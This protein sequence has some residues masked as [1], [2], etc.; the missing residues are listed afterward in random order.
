MVILAVGRWLI[1]KKSWVAVK[2]KNIFADCRDTERWSGIIKKFIPPLLLTGLVFLV[3]HKS[4]SYFFAQDDFVWLRIAASVKKATQLFDFFL[5]YNGAGSYRPLTQEVFFFL[6][7]KLFGLNPVP[8][9]LVT[10]CVHTI[11]SLLVYGILRQMKLPRMACLAGAIF[12]GLNS[13]VFIPVYWI[14]AISESGMALFY[15]S[16]VLLFLRY[17]QEGRRIDYCLSFAACVFALMSKEPAITIPAILLLTYLY[18]RN[19]FTM[20][21]FVRGVRLVLPFVAVVAVYLGIRFAFVGIV[22]GG[23]YKPEFNTLI[24][25]NLWDFFKWSLNDLGLT[26]SLLAQ[27]TQY[28]FLPAIHIAFMLLLA[29]AGLFLFVKEKR[30][31]LFSIL[32]FVIALVPVLPYV[33]HAQNYYVNI[34]VVG[35]SVLVA[36]LVSKY[37]GRAKILVGGLMALYILSSVANVHHQED[38]SW[39]AVRSRLAETGIKEMKSLFPTL[40]PDS[41][42][43]LLNTDENDYWAYN[44][45]DL[46]RDYYYNNMMEI[47]FEKKKQLPTVFENKVNLF[48]VFKLGGH[49]Y[50]V[51]K[52]FKQ[53]KDARKIY[54]QR[55]DLIPLESGGLSNLIDFS[56][57]SWENQLL[58]G[59]HNIEPGGYRWMAKTSETLLRNQKANKKEQLHLL[60]KGSA[61]LDHY[62]SGKVQMIL[63][64]NGTVIA[65][66]LIE[67]TGDYSIEAD[68]VG[69]FPQT[70]RLAI[71]LDKSFVPK[72]VTNSS[73]T[74][75]LGVTVSLIELW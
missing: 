18:L 29:C 57:G 11:N 67:R 47:F 16:S 46:F 4:L 3:F 37:G 26:L 69:N 61:V 70:V 54:E 30:V 72:H 65:K 56:K 62:P 58:R 13:S 24:L 10:L 45:G 64:I 28:R 74:R 55:F 41:V 44:F 12:Y 2:V 60:M 23:P 48:V 27:I 75:E 36:S 40:S 32:W 59:W 6:N 1:T 34:S 5:Q 39:V 35:I 66:K 20:A 73:D 63:R 17:I 25:G 19:T 14:S 53:V 49:L 22:G 50:D 43:Y 9:H 33:H 8:F 15:L 51:T 42:L 68:F 38:Y 31:M 52:Q 21:G 7:Y 71:E